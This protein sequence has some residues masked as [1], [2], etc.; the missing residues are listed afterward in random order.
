MKPADFLEDT[1]DGLYRIQGHRIGLED[2]VFFHC[3]GYSPEMIVGQFPT[4]PLALAYKVVAYYL[5]NRA[6]VDDYVA[7]LQQIAEQQ[8]AAAQR[9]PDME[10]LRRRLVKRQHLE[11]S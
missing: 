6:D 5:E 9:G 3:E 8:R 4:L 10:E 11:A 1:G 2:V 7:R